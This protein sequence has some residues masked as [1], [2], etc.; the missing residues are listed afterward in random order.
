MSSSLPGDSFPQFIRMPQINR[1]LQ[2]PVLRL[3][4]LIE[5]PSI[6]PVIAGELIRVTG[7]ERLT[8]SKEPADRFCH[9]LKSSSVSRLFEA[10]LRAV[11]RH[12]Q[13]AVRILHS[14]R[15]LLTHKI[16]APQQRS[17]RPDPHFLY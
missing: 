7:I 17:A 8:A 3:M 5:H 16:I 14:R 12:D 11:H 10:L 15:F 4:F 1:E 13:S 2:R 6:I 9:T